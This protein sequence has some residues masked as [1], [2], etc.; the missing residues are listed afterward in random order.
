MKEAASFLRAGL[1][2]RV[3]LVAKWDPGLLQHQELAPGISVC[4]IK[5]AA[6]CLPRR[7]PWQI[8]KEMEW[9][10]RV[11]QLA[12]ELRPRTIFCHSVM[13]LRTAVAAKR[14]TGAA[15]VY[16]AHELETERIGFNGAR[17]ARSLT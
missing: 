7:L 13:P 10:H 15:L 16:D 6:R 2:E 12:R 11:V 14:A 4:R 9:R 1:A 17:N 8:F 5:L 3:I